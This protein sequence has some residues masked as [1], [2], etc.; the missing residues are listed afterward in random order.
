MISLLKNE[1]VKI[2]SR[3]LSK[4]LFLLL[5][6][7]SIGT[8]IVGKMQHTENANWKAAE[9]KVI[10]ENENRIQLSSLSPQLKADA[11]NKVKMAKYRLKNQQAPAKINPWSAILKVSGLIEMVIILIIIVAAE[12]VSR[13]F[14]DGTIK[15]LLIRPHRRSKILLSK[16]LTLAIFSGVALL[17]VLVSQFF[18]NGFLYGFS[19]LFTTFHSTDLFISSQGQVVRLSNISQLVKLYGLS[20]FSIMNYGTIAFAISTLLRNSALAVGSSLFL[21]IMGN[22]MI[23]ATS[24]IAWLKYLPFANS[25]FSLYIYH[26]APRPE[27]TIGFSL[28]VLIAYMI[29][30][31]VISFYSFNKRDII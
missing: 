24:K 4:I 3:R 22:S 25:D 27:M 26:L 31:N 18:I 13:E 6:L 21:M 7:F 30:F 9:E 19:H 29:L 28:M 1:L 2:F 20:F 16:Y 11:Q 14:N 15:L 10:T 12:M 17:L 8:A 5:L 23:E